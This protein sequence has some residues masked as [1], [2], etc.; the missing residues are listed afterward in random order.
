MWLPAYQVPWAQM[1]I[2]AEQCDLKGQ[3]AVLSRKLSF[4]EVLPYC[5]R[6]VKTGKGI[7]S[8]MG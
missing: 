4:S 6:L 2:F 7:F 5:R 1:L 3:V 8:V